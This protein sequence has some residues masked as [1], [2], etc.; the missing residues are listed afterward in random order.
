MYVVLDSLYVNSTTF[1]WLQSVFSGYNGTIMAYGQTGTG[2]TYTVGNLGKTDASE[3]GI[4][5][6]AVEDIIANTSLDH[7]SVEVSY[8]QVYDCL[9]IKWY[10]SPVH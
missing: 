6:R 1:T 9:A 4:I 10:T 7:E 5:V 3:R 2:K 8:L